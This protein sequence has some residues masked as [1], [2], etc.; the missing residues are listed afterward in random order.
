M[1]ELFLTFESIR[2]DSGTYMELSEA[3]SLLVDTDI[4]L[5]N[6]M[7]ENVLKIF[8]YPK[9]GAPKNSHLV[10]ELS[11]P[12]IPKKKKMHFL[13]PNSHFLFYFA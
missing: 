1:S 6:I 10:M 13:S 3:L 7:I 11:H 12:F 2:V 4:F 5:L 9:K 8:F